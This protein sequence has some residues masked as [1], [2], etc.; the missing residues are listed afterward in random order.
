MQ[1]DLDLVLADAELFRYF[2][3]LVHI[4]VPKQKYPS[5]LG[6]QLAEELVER[7]SESYHIAQLF[8]RRI[9]CS[10]V[11]KLLQQQLNVS[12]TALLSVSL[13]P[14]VQRSVSRQKSISS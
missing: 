8:K 6:F 7:L 11:G 13:A 1:A 14:V 10:H 2:F 4:P 12:R 3:Y 9:R 5:L